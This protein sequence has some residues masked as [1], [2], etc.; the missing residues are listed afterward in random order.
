MLLH[1]SRHGSHPQGA[2]TSTSLLSQCRDRSSTLTTLR[3]A[4][5]P[6]PKLHL[7]PFTASQHGKRPHTSDGRAKSPTRPAH[8]HG[9]A[10]PA[11]P[12]PTVHPSG[13][14]AQLAHLLPRHAVFLLRL[15]IHELSNVPLVHGEFE[16]RW[17][18]K[19]VTSGGGLLGKVKGRGKAMG[20]TTPNGGANSAKGKEKEKPHEGEMDAAGAVDASDAHSVANSNSTHSHDAPIPSVI[21]SANTLISP[22]TSSASPHSRLH[23]V[24]VP[25][26]YL[27]ADWLPQTAPPD[28]TPSLAKSPPTAYSPAKGHTAFEQLRDHGVEWEQTLDIMVQMGIGRE[29]NELGGCEAKF[30][31]MQRVIP[32]DPDAPRNPRLGAVSINLAQ[33]VDAGVVTRRY[34]LRQSKTNATLKLTVQLE[35]IGGESSYIAPPLPK[36][37]ILS[38]IAGL[39]DKDVFRTRPRTIDL[40]AHDISSSSSLSTI[41]TNS[42]GKRGRKKKRQN[43]L[44][45]NQLPNTRGVHGT[46]KLI[47]ALFNPAPVTRPGLLTPFTYLLEPEVQ[48]HDQ[49]REGTTEDGHVCGEDEERLAEESLYMHSV[50]HNHLPVRQDSESDYQSV[51]SKW[52]RSLRAPSMKS[53]RSVNRSGVNELGVSTAISNTT[54]VEKRAWWRKV[55]RAEAAS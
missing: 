53:I 39:L 36:G 49:S 16:V 52:S 3:P 25:P 30:I 21:V 32:G 10:S 1:D 44:D 45:A 11:S 33:Y 17:K 35:H 34:L 40:Y 26:Q 31:V 23:N 41:S 46:E 5:K 27:S 54:I 20:S 22:G 8:S 18:F 12:T 13:F 24:N 2:S 29:T 42:S 51:H 9:H 7:S 48:E 38:G 43:P 47:E 14:R 19:G 50:D 37:E 6:Y 55:L 15:T 4:K 28:P